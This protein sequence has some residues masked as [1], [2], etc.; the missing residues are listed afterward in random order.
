M[1]PEK[2]GCQ[3]KTKV[4]KVGLELYDL[5]NDPGERNNLASQYPDIFDSLSVI[6]DRMREK[7]GD[8]LTGI[9]GCEVRPSGR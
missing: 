6:D 3:G 9:K 4:L 8:K 7:L 2:D 5:E 1:K